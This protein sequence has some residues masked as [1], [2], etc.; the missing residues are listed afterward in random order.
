MLQYQINSGIYVLNEKA[1]DYLPEK[2]DF[3]MDVFPEM[4][5]KREKLSGYVF[6]D[7][8][9]DVG[10]LHDYERINQTLSLV[11]LITQK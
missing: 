7:Y 5:R 1:F 10:N 4:L 2:G 9:I 8:W 3:A 11:D 6:D